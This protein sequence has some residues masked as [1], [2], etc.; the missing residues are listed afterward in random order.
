MR[1]KRGGSEVPRPSAAVTEDLPVGAEVL[2][3]EEPPA[4]EP[5]QHEVARPVKRARRARGGRGR[6]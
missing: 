2:A 1:R 5:M 6:G 3:V 4:T